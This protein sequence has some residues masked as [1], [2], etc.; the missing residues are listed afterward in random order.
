MT[1]HMVEPPQPRWN[2]NMI[3]VPYLFNPAIPQYK[4]RSI[5]I[6]APFMESANVFIH[7]EVTRGK[8]IQVITTP[9]TPNQGEFYGNTI[10]LEHEDQ[11]TEL[12]Q[13][14]IDF[15]RFIAYKTENKPL[16]KNPNLNLLSMKSLYFTVI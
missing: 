2:A 8:V 14:G 15:D 16:D 5:I 11:T 13:Y 6:Y 12:I 10:T 4:N 1:S 3:P 9:V 7:K